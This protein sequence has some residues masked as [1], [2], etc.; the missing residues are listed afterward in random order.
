MA[1]IITRQVKA[2][3]NAAITA[4]TTSLSHA[5]LDTNF[6]AIADGSVYGGTKDG[7]KFLR[8]DM[9]WAAA[10]GGGPHTHP[11]SEI[12]DSTATGRALVTATDAAAGRTAIGAGTSSF[13][14]AYADLSGKPTLGSAA[15]AATTDFEAAGAVATHAAAADPHTAYALESA[16]G[17]SA[18]LNVG[19]TA[20]TVAAGD[21]THPGGS[22]AFPIGSV[23][24]AVVST[25]PATLLGY[26]TWSAFG[27]GRMLVGRDAGDVDFDTAE[28]T[29]GAKTHTLTSAETPSH[30]HVQD[31]HTHTQDSHNHTQDAHTHTQNAH[32][33]SQRYH[34]ATTG[35]LSGLTTAPDTSSNTPTN[36]GLVTA[37]A[38]A[39]NQNAT[40][41]NQAATAT[42]QNATATNQNTGGGGAHN[43]MPPYIVCYF[44]KRTA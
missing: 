37:D 38:T 26:G 23:F 39:V 5:E 18:A 40:A 25:S 13:S 27:A 22:E 12:S 8:D 4:N 3:T 17:N 28:E 42:N 10:S 36:Y 20:G 44:W 33:H 31:A 11:A 15:A 21:H 19:T 2:A 7:T 6:A 34:S 32:N 35:P 41:T 14:G 16:L 9:T 29:G 43:N 24:L 1:E 30:T